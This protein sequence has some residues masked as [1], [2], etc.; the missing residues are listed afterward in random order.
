[1][2][3]DGTSRYFR[4][5]LSVLVT[6]A[7]IYLIGQLR[8]FFHDIWVVLRALVVPFIAAMVVSYL[9]EPVVD[10]L[11]RRRVP[12][13]AAILV[14]YVTGIVLFAVALLHSIP[15]FSRQLSQLTANLPDLVVQADR[16]M[17]EIAR[18]KDGLPDALR[19]GVETGLSNLEQQVV[20]FAARLT[21]VVTGTVNALFVVFLV[22]F[23]VFYMLK[24]AK[25]IGRAIVRLFPPDRR[26]EVREVLHGIDQTLGNYVRGQLL[27]MLA[28][29]LLT[30]AGLLVVQMPYAFLLALI[31]GVTNV[32]PYL[33]PFLGAA[34]ALLLALSISP[35]MALKVLLVNVIVQQCEGNLISPQIMGRTLDLHP[36]A[37]VAAVIIGGEMA[38]VFGLVVAVPVL[39]V[40][41]VVWTHV[42]SSGQR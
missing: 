22:P 33:G 5:A 24:D 38:G 17:D 12:R 1:L 41:K 39:A 23:L 16:W 11:T 8:G 7:C 35:L 14:I 9:L 3:L 31:V 29:F 32:I 25:A 26:D 4:V 36:L 42:R 37:I 10:L 2:P 19:R 21:G 34:P 20:G 6:L 30:Y 27:V 40:A 13:G 18:R 28:V 15:I